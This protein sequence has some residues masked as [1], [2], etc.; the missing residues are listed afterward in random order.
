MSLSLSLSLGVGGGTVGACPASLSLDWAPTLENGRK[1]ARLEAVPVT[2]LTNQ[3]DTAPRA[4]RPVLTEGGR[5]AQEERE[6]EETRDKREREEK[7]ESWCEV[8]FGGQ[9]SGHCRQAGD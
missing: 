5:G 3:A 4:T 1:G 2:V 8:V 9:T 6:R 7:R